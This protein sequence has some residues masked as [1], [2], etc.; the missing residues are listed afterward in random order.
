MKNVLIGIILGVAILSLR[1]I[2]K[3]NKKLPEMPV[4]LFRILLAACFFV[5]AFLLFYRVDEIPIPYHVDEAGM[6]YDAKSLAKY[7]TDRWGYHNPVYLI[8]YGG[9]QS[10]LY[11]YLAALA[12]KIFGYSVISVRLPAIL[13][14]L[15]SLV[16]FAML[17]RKEF[18]NTASIIAAA[19]FCLLPF[20]IMHSR[21]GLDAYLLFPMLI[22]ACAAFYS[23]VSSGRIPMFI[24]S[25]CLFGLT[26][27]SYAVSYILVPFF[28][29]LCLIPLL[30][31]KR[32]SLQQLAALLLPIVISAVPLIL[33]LAVNNGLMEE[34]RTPYFSVP[35]L[36]AYRGSEFSFG[37]ILNNLKFGERNIFY[38]I[39]V[40][41]SLLYNMV[42]EFGSMY[43]FTIPLI[44]FGFVICGKGSIQ[45]IK[46]GRFSLN[47]MMV[48]L[49]MVIFTVQL[50][51]PYSNANRACAIYFP[52]IY[53]LVIGI[54]ELARKS[55][56]ALIAAGAVCL[57]FAFS[58]ARY[59]FTS[60]SHDLT[61]ELS[62]TSV[63]DL[64]QALAFAEEV[65]RENEPVTV[66]GL[67]QPYLYTLLVKDIDPQTFLASYAMK[68][69]N[70]V[71]FGNYRFDAYPVSP[72]RVY[73][74]RTYGW[75]P[76]E[77]REAPFN[78]ADF[79]TVTVY[80]P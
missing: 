51:L 64:E 32:L 77:I 73:L 20:S 67:S 38:C 31:R 76:Y 13:F 18:G 12:I 70:V 56:I 26:L 46:A 42:P 54:L 14:S 62:I 63:A 74:L 28:L 39:F 52:L 5:F 30:F 80:Y 68:D 45:S 29:G 33:L 1:L 59:Y 23:A 35:K 25:G 65:S 75:V 8:N 40:R 19:V 22:F 78:M 17:I 6:V 44:L 61:R 10:A 49:F 47:L 53:F 55:R 15:A 24:L 37:N 43:Y 50:L 57:F 58:F 4:W 16:V 48:L 66:Y 60:F 36:F 71:S 34:I 41:D 11:M 2:P 9:G 72:E 3:K 21:W 27:Y 69:V 7:G 79:G